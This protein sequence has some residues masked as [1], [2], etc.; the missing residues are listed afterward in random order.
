[1]TRAIVGFAFAGVALVTAVAW[2]LPMPPLELPPVKAMGLACQNV[3]LFPPVPPPSARGCPLLHPERAAEYE[4]LVEVDADGSVIAAGVPGER[5]ASVDAC[6]R[7]ET[8][9]WTFEP[10]RRCDGQAVPGEY[11]TSYALVFGDG[12]ECSRPHLRRAERART[13][14]AGG[15]TSGCS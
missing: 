7:E 15:R 4:V 8:R 1:M 6:V 2:L 9:R 3:R 13:F 11:R 10:A 5:S 12:T 14:A